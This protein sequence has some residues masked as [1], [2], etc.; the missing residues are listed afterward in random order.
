MPDKKL[1]SR[2]A[3][4]VGHIPISRNR[5]LIKIDHLLAVCFQI[6]GMSAVQIAFGLE[7]V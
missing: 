4:H 7:L 5:L 3:N 6:V 2:S 1:M